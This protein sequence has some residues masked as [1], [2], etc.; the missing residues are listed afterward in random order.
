MTEFKTIELVI[1]DAIATLT[2][3]QPKSLN[4][5]TTEVLSEIG[6]AIEEV[7]NNLDIR[8]LIITGAGEKSFVA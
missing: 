2:I 7:E 8:A 5:L 4:A 6:Q 3:N 1:E